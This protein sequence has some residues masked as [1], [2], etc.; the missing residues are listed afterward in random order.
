MFMDIFNS[1][2]ISLIIVT[3]LTARVII[4]ENKH[5]EILKLFQNASWVINL[6][7]VIGFSIYMVNTAGNDE[8]GQKIKDAV[9]KGILAFI[10]A[11]LETYLAETTQD[12]SDLSQALENE[13]LDRIAFLAHRS[14]AAFKMV[15]LEDVTEIAQ[16]IEF[17]AKN[18]NVTA[19]LLSIPVK[20][21]INEAMASFVAVEQELNSLKG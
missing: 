6:I 11:M 2:T 10:I 13:D 12:I 4:K 17:T 8:E 16:N 18:A 15:G 1:K 20:S 14:K 5:K 9:K 3:L 19:K 21:L 7:I